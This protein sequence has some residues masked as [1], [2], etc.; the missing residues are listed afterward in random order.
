MFDIEEQRKRIFWLCLAASGVLLIGTSVMVGLKLGKKE[1]VDF[2]IDQVEI[3]LFWAGCMAYIVFHPEGNKHN[4][5]FR[6]RQGKLKLVPN[7][8]PHDPEGLR[9]LGLGIAVVGFTAFVISLKA[10]ISW[11]LP[12]AYR[13][14]SFG[15]LAISFVVWLTAILVTIIKL[16]KNTNQ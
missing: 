10:I 2:V 3:C 14:I 6:I 1:L 8:I 11:N 16:K 5:S 12:A 13:V 15:L 4:Y 7:Q 9:F